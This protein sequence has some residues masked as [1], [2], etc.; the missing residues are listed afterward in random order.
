MKF[1]QN[2]TLLPLRDPV[3]SELISSWPLAESIKC[4]GHA[5]GVIEFGL[6]MI[7]LPTYIAVCAAGIGSPV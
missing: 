5:L 7:A 2:V 6:S 1:P 4:A 3:T